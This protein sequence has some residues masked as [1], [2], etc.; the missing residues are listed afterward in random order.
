MMNQLKQTQQDCCPKCETTF[1]WRGHYH[2]TS[3]NQG[4]E[5]VGYCPDCNAVLEKLQACGAA[6]YFCN[7]C[8]LLKSKSTINFEY[9]PIAAA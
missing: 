1:E 5:K 8:K 2:C 9:Q 7:S 3:C 6:N 4:F